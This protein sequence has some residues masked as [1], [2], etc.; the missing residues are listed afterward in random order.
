[1]SPR[2]LLTVI[3]TI[4]ISALPNTQMFQKLYYTL[5]FEAANME[6]VRPPM[7]L[8]WAGVGYR[9]KVDKHLKM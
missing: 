4:F 3:P 9:S 8:W 6:A 2:M 7:F 5:Y 1:M